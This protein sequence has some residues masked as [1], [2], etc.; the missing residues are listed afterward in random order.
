MRQATS[1]GLDFYLQK[2]RASL[3]QDDGVIQS[4]GRGVENGFVG[5]DSICGDFHWMATAVIQTRVDDGLLQGE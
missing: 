4:S 2:S 5:G 3:K 1:K